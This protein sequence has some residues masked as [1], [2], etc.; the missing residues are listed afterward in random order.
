MQQYH[1]KDGSEAA[2][3]TAATAQPRPSPFKQPPKR[4]VATKTKN[5]RVASTP[6]PE[7]SAKKVRTN[8]KAAAPVEDYKEPIHKAP[9]QAEQAYTQQEQEYASYYEAQASYDQ[10]QPVYGSY[11]Q[12]YAEYSA[13]HHHH[14]SAAQPPPPPPFPM[15]P[16]ANHASHNE[17]E[18]LSNLIMAWYYSGY[19]TG[20]YQ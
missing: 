17:D 4:T 12:N 14:M 3:A 8:V 15:P 19:Y 13:P 9:E 11:Q 20:Y 2:V 10:S 1:S 6:A 7:G 16:S 5:K 18:A